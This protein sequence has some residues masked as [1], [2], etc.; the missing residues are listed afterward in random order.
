VTIG[1]SREAPKTDVV[2]AV[3]QSFLGARILCCKCHN[4]P[5]EKYT[6]DD[7]YHFAAFFSAVSLDRQNPA[8]GP[9]GLSVMTPGEQDQRK[10][11]ADLE[12]QLKAIE[13]S[14]SGK[15]EEET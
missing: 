6:Q 13:I 8:K 15:T 12:K 5:D 3:A 10:R 7:Y 4:H 1:E 2:S 14:L 11:H 9:T